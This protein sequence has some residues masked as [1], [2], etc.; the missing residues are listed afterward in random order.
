MVSVI[1]P[2]YNRKD[3]L[4]QAVSSVAA[5]TYR[6]FEL[7]IVD[8]GSTDGLKGILE[9]ADAGAAETEAELQA[10]ENVL[11][12][13]FKKSEQ[14]QY[15]SIPHSGF[16]GK[17]R[18][19]G[20]R[21]AKGSLIAFLDSDDL[22]CPEK[23][24]RQVSLLEK[25][26]EIPLVHTREIW[27][28]GEKTVSQKSQKHLREGN[29]F[30]DS[31]KKCIIGPSTVCMKRSFLDKIGWFREDLE[32]AEDYELW[33]R[34][35]SRSPVGYIDEPLTVKRAG[36]GKQ[37]LSEKYGQIEIFRIL[38]LMELVEAGWFSADASALGSACR[39]MAERELQR[40]TAI[41]AA[42]ARKRG[43]EEEAEQLE[44]RLAK[45]LS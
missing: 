25:H 6:N 34:L 40:K 21:A 42:G 28:R 22:W 9:H 19:A 27:K 26:P 36:H 31:L 18:N 15:L 30:A 35:T 20:I 2:V 44:R 8:D 23:L 17:V 38:G 13:G 12:K 41:Y 10:W 39:D 11:P 32:V 4:F 43:R 29:I 45:I 5:Q 7:I 37:Q 14:F 16:P 24:E 1:I 3:L 33:L